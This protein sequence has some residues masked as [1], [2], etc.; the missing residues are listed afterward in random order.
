MNDPTTVVEGIVSELSFDQSRKPYL[1]RAA[2]AVLIRDNKKRILELWSENLKSAYPELA[3]ESKIALYDELPNYL[4]GIA[5]ALSVTDPCL[6]PPVSVSQEHG[7]QRA[8]MTEFSLK[9]VIEEFVI[10]RNAIF[11][12]LE[13]KSTLDA[14]TRDIIFHSISQGIVESA[15]EYTKIQDSFRE[16]FIAIVTHDLRNPL[17]TALMSAQ[18]IKR[19]IS[20]PDKCLALAEK[21]TSSV[22]RAD[23][24]LQYLLDVSQIRAG[25]PIVVDIQKGELRQVVEDVVNELKVIHGDRFV[26]NAAP[27]IPALFCRDGIRRA[28]E[29]LITNAV[30]YGDPSGKITI[31]IFE[32]KE[33]SL[34]ISVQNSGKTI[35]PEILNNLFNPYYR[36]RSTKTQEQ[37]GWGLGLTLVQGIAVSH[38]GSVSVE[39]SFEFG[40]TFTI[41][42]PQKD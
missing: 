41:K 8:N 11:N 30:K 5:K 20:Q 26:L 4:E 6:L 13:E 36:N 15:T 24:M 2:A 14:E 35:A 22:N 19:T 37:R 12:L 21:I 10:L 1:G 28:V 38:G 39:S 9:Q 7:E 23:R 25:K 32:D 33:K 34:S 3:Q 31:Q 40:T 18:L 29:N 17:A 27:K 16:Q 42:I